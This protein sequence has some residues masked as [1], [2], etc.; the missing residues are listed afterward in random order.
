MSDTS[1]ALTEGHKQDP[2]ANDV[3]TT[4]KQP[5]GAD[6]KPDDTRTTTVPLSALQQERKARQDLEQRLAQFEK[7]A[8]ERRK[9]E[10]SEVERAKAE[11]E[12]A[13]RERDDLRQQLE[14]TERK[15]WVRA[16]A[17][18]YDFIDVEDAVAH[19]SERGELDSLE[20]E[21]AAREAVKKIRDLR[22]HLTAKQKQDPTLHE[23][24]KDGERVPANGNGGADKPPKYTLEDIKAMT[25]EQIQRDL[26]EVNRSLQLQS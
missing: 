13:A 19:L 1:T 4:Q 26:D 10:M 3:D 17:K 6:A 9:A 18:H 22:P 7:E 12:E 21:R 20:D 15:S 2:P 23:V 14:R 16:A 8:E 11:A 25:P 5:G 24:L